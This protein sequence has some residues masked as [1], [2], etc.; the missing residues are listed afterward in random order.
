MARSQ[1][2]S[3]DKTNPAVSDSSSSAKQGSAKDTNEDPEQLTEDTRALAGAQD[4]SLG[5][6]AMTRSFWQPLVGLAFTADTNPLILRNSNG[7]VTWTSAFAGIDMHRISRGSDFTLNFLG[8]GLTANNSHGDRSLV[9]EL[10]LN[11]KLMW[12]RGTVSFFEQATYLPESAFGSAV[13][14]GASFPDAQGQSLQPVL[15]PNQ[16]ILTTRG[17]RI[18]QS[19][20]T[21]VDKF[22]T[23]RSSLTFVG[24]YSLL[25]FFDNGMLNSGQAS[26]QAGYNYQLTSKDTIALLYRFSALRFP[27]F[28][29]SINGH[30]AQIAFGRRVTGR[31]AFRLAVGPEF[32]FLSLPVSTGTGTATGSTNTIASAGPYW[33]LDASTTYRR[34][35]TEF[36]L[37]YDRSVF[38]G[39]GVI[40]GAVTNQVSG[41]INSHVTT[42]LRGAF[43]LGYAGNRGLYVT[44]PAPAPPSYNYWFSGLNFS[45][46]WGRWSNVFLN[47]QA[48]FQDSNSSFCLG[49]TCGKSFVRHAISIGLGWRPRPISLQ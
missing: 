2:Q 35:H 28:D 26:F 9:Q 20:A 1:E 18:S 47:Y 23:P 17:Q 33:A 30:I 36:E 3:N 37:T 15:T 6:S 14:A 34:Q 25:H 27:N 31:L 16:S 11:E 24:S 42:N 12:P 40:A 7:L 46:A 4:L 21:E 22:L 8:S 43:V 13:S 29:E 32:T 44:P 49:T 5:T 48:Q 19:F 10:E 45:R 38:G 41:S 39:S